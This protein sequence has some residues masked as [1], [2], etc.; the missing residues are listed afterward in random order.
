MLQFRQASIQV[1][2]H[3]G[4][5]K[6]SLIY[7]AE[8]ILDGVAQC[9]KWSTVISRGSTP[10]TYHFKRKLHVSRFTVYLGTHHSFAIR[11]IVLLQA[12]S[13][14]MMSVEIKGVV[15]MR[16]D[17]TLRRETDQLWDEIDGSC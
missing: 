10:C 6:L 12:H 8:S 16:I 1:L 17:C 7:C 13:S 2:W 15:M 9:H 4:L 5:H 11:K 3:I 14:I